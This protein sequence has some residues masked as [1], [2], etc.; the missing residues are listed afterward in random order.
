M[1]RLIT[2]EQG[3]KVRQIGLADSELSRSARAVHWIRE[4]YGHPFRVDD[5]A[6]LIELSASACSRSPFT[7]LLRGAA[8]SRKDTCRGAHGLT[9]AGGVSAGRRAEL[10]AIL[11]AEL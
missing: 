11:A 4:N 1:W 5:M 7:I 2:G 10:A 3:S 9:Q 6:E 8:G